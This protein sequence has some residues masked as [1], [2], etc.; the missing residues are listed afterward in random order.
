M[1]YIHPEQKVTVKYNYWDY[2]DSFNKSLLYENAN[3]KHS[4]FIKICSNVFGRQIPNWFCKWWIDIS[5]KLI[6]FQRDNIFFE[7]M[8]LMYFFIEFSIPWIMKW[9]V[10][11]DNTYEGFPS[12]QRTFYTKFW[13]KLVHKDL[14]GKSEAIA[15]YMEE[16]KRD[17]IKNLDI[18]IGDDISMASTSHTNN[19]DEEGIAGEAKEEY[20]IPQHL[21]LLNKWTIPKISPRITYHT[22]T[23]EKLGLKHVVKTSEETITIDINN[24]TFRLLFENDLAPYWDIYRFIHIGLVQVAFKPLTLRGLPE[25]FITALRDCRNHNWKKSL[26][27][28]IQTSLAYRP[29]YFNAYPNL[30]ISLQDENSLSSLMLNVKLHGYHYI[31]GTEVVCICYRIYYKLLHTLNPMCKKLILVNLKLL[32]DDLLGGK[33]LTFHKSGLSRVLLN[34]EI[35][36]IQRFQKLNS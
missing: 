33:R 8:S 21:D 36:L 14:E 18:D 20:D 35:I 23:F 13:N 17:L 30:Q 28:T 6:S 34:L 24:Q 11:V 29:I 1:D 4:R 25:S 12:L 2:V 7:G 9:S 3:R 32:P 27:G 10:E 19:D 26:I 15:M 5:P 16:V 31:L 22:G